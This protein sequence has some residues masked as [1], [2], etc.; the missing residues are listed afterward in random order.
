MVSQ[1]SAVMKQEEKGTIPKVFSPPAAVFPAASVAAIAPLTCAES[2]ANFFWYP[3]TSASVAE[4][5]SRSWYGYNGTITRFLLHD[6]GRS[7]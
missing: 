5:S 1:H 3:F 4:A 7:P 2:C 6:P